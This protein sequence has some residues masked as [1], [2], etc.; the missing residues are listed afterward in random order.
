MENI[1]TQNIE[2]NN[3]IKLYYRDYNNMKY[4]MS[5]SRICK[6]RERLNDIERQIKTLKNEYNK[7]TR[8]DK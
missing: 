8:L 7:V 5:M 3:L 6:L 1:D 4:N 2:L